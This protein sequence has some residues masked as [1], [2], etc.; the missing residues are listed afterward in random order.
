VRPALINAAMSAALASALLFAY[1]LVVIRPAQ[2]IG[3]VDVGEVYR[4]KEAEFAQALT[5]GA[6][7]E[8]RGR[9]LASAR[10]FAQRLP[11]ALEELPRECGCLV[12]LKT[13]I[14]GSTPNTVDLTGYLKAKVDAK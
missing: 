12:V 6:G 1:H 8:D 11:V 13:A 5:K 9:A 7:D 14:A 4:L 3:V 2:R 10:L